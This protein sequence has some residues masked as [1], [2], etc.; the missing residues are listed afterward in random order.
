[1]IKESSSW[2]GTYWINKFIEKNETELV[3]HGFPKG[4]RISGEAYPK[5]Y[6]EKIDGMLGILEFIVETQIK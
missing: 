2:C 3:K 4:L 5:N 1:L 6:R